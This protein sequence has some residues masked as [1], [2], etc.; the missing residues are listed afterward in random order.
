MQSLNIHKRKPYEKPC[1]RQLN[2]EQ[3]IR[4]LLEHASM[5]HEGAKELLDLL[6]P[7]SA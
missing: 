4:L 2:S 3:A 6:F 5:G 1:I 7:K